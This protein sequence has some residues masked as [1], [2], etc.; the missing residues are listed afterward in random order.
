MNNIAVI[1]AGGS[2]ERFWPMSRMK[3]PKQFLNLFSEH[4]MI[5]ETFLRIKSFIDSDKIFII[6]PIN[7]KEAIKS[8]IPEILES[9]IIF[10][11]FPRDTAAAIGLS[12]LYVHN[13]FPDANLLICA[14][15]HFISDLS[16]FEKDIS[17]GLK[18][19]SENDAI[20][21]IGIKPERPET[22]YGYIELGQVEN[23]SIDSKVF[24]VLG[25]TE[26]P[27]KKKAQVLYDSGIFYW[28]SGMFIFKTSIILSEIEKHMPELSSALK[29][30]EASLGKADEEEVKQKALEPLKKISIDYGVMEYCKNILC[31][32]STFQWDDVGS[33]SSLSRHYE[34]DQ[35]GNVTL[36]KSKIYQTKNSIVM[37]DDKHAI[38]VVGLNNVIVVQSDNGILVCNK[39]MEQDIKTI[40]KKMKEDDEYNEFT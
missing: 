5:R 18:L 19:A 12:A 11:P 1:M 40:L 21:T 38:A 25:F 2:G 16:S 23:S 20:I 24:K 4:S 15:D 37:G 14:S 31:I 32:E 17:G 3:K 10:E 35:L 7:Y 33:F 30:I 9:N 39:D 28:N 36:G 34:L 27:D 29:K 13:K 26:K 8:E 22:K 6:A